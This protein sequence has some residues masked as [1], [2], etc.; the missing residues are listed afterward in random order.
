M[1]QTH[2]SLAG[3][4]RQ[5]AP[6]PPPGPAESFEARAAEIL[7]G[8]EPVTAGKLHLISFVAIKEHFVF[9]WPH[10]ALKAEGLMRR[11][12]DT[13]RQPGNDRKSCAG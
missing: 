10:M 3:V 12:I 7:G 5:A 8:R 4:S 2:T 9:D 13:A 1:T 11:A 6:V